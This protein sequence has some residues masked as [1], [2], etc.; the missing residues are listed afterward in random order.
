MRFLY[1]FQYIKLYL[2]FILILKGEK[3]KKKENNELFYSYFIM[4][5]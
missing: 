3:K 5:S 1:I 4:Q 2:K